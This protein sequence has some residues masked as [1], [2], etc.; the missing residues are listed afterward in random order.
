VDENNE[1]AE[2][3]KQK[4]SK[5]K[6]KRIFLPGGKK[7]TVAAEPKEFLGDI[8][9]LESAS[10]SARTDPCL[11]TIENLFTNRILMDPAGYKFMLG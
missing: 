10:F 2:E 1:T 3:A 5:A 4:R 6:K 8:P 7:Q 9:K 11:S